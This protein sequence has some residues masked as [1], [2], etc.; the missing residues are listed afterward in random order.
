MLYGFPDNWRVDLD[1]SQSETL[2]RIAQSLRVEDVTERG[3]N[4]SNVL[5][6]VCIL[7]G[8]V[9]HTKYVQQYIC[10]LWS[11]RG[12]KNFIRCFI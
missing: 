9:R 7:Q 5:F 10:M 2:R 1:R 3:S 6:R 12:I 8:R 4:G 11:F